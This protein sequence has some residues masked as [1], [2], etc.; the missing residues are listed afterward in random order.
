M[1]NRM[2]KS[3][4]VLVIGMSSICF[5]HVFAQTEGFTRKQNQ[6]VMKSFVSLFEIP[7]TNL[8]RAV[9]FY[10]S[11]LDIK[12]EQ[13]EVLDMEM[14]IFP[15]EGQTVHGVIIKGDGYVPSSKGVTIYLNAGNDLQYALDKVEKNGG[16]IIVPKTAHADDSGFF[17]LFL[18][19]EGNRL[20]L[21]SPN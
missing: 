14:G 15:Y 11:I 17:A 16:K 7:A 4:M 12:I 21:N 19:T 9:R 8:S 3:V 2:S 5:N 1:K 13:M 18:D 10:Q 20:G 6:E